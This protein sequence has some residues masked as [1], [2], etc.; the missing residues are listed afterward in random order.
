MVG[1]K[2]MPT[3]HPIQQVVLIDYSARFLIRVF[4]PAFHIFPFFHFPAA[5][6]ALAA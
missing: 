5:L 2:E 1:F 3:V 6:R 4:A